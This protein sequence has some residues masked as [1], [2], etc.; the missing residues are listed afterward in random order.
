MRVCR[1]G[2]LFW[3]CCRRTSAR[4]VPRICHAGFSV[5]PGTFVPLPRRR[6]LP[7]L[8]PVWSPLSQ[9]R[10][11]SPGISPGAAP[12][13]IL[14]RLSAL[15]APRKPD[16]MQFEGGRD[17]TPGEAGDSDPVMALQAFCAGPDILLLV[18]RQTALEGWALDP[19][20]GA[21]EQWR[22]A[23]SQVRGQEAGR[24]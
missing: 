22:L 15:V 16:G 19:S 2:R 24:K 12:P 9:R 8:D 7:G 14:A 6:S 10:E 11:Q 17:A 20:T 5:C 23:S 21:E 4:C 18:A 3:A 1:G 13:S